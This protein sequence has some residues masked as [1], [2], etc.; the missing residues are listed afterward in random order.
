MNRLI[1]LRKSLELTPI[2][3]LVAC[4][5]LSP[6]A[7]AQLPPPPPDGGYP[8]D[9][10]AEGTNALF[11]VT[12]GTDNT[13][14]GATALFSNTTANNN[15]ATGVAALESNTTGSDN[16][17]TGAFALRFNTKIGRAHV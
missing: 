12:I 11:N 5:T 16:T 15:T 2:V 9:N 8:N 17:A 6:T 1:Q 7:Q 4:F 14:T 10:T 13:A 3:F